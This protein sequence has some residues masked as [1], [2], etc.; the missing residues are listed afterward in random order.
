MK[1]NRFT[2]LCDEVDR[3]K[4]AELANF[5]RRTQSDTMRLLLDAAHRQTIVMAAGPQGQEGG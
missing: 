1:D 3:R 5:Y 2:F 4:I